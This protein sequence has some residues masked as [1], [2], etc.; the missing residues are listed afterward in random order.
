MSRAT[1]IIRILEIRHVES[2]LYV[3]PVYSFTRFHSHLKT[4][5][6]RLE[7]NHFC[8]KKGIQGNVRSTLYLKIKNLFNLKQLTV[9]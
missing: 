2:V 9:L 8:D 3:V 1:G 5:K 6:N 4:H 7:S